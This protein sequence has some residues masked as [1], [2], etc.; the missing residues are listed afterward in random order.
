M[1]TPFHGRAGRV[2]ALLATTAALAV[3]ALWQAG[4]FVG[5]RIAPGTVGVPVETIEVAA[6]TTAILQEVARIHEIVGTVISRDQVDVSPRITARIV[7]IERRSGDTVAAGDV[8]ATLDDLD[9][10]ASFRAAEQAY[11]AAQSSF[12]NARSGRTGAQAALE[13]AEKEVR[14]MRELDDSKT[15]SKSQLDQSEGAYRAARAAFA[16]AEAGV[17]TAAAEVRRAA[18]NVNAARAFLDYTVLRS[19]LDGVV[20]DR[21]ADPGDMA[22]V[23][24]PI[25]RVFDP[26]RLM[27]EAS[28]REEFVSHVKLGMKARFFV[29]AIGHVAEGE[30]REIV[31]AV[32]PESRTFLVKLCLGREPKIVPGMF[33][34]LY[35]PVGS[36][37]VLS[38]PAE[39]LRRFGQL[40]IVYVRDGERIA[41]RFVKTAPEPPERLRVLSGLSEGERIVLPKGRGDE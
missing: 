8:L 41:R 9:L 16:Q 11:A 40:E 5:G 25:L 28:V 22:T 14:R 38:I 29:G 20:Y 21:L 15:V 3:L 23:G 39:F 35:L 34:R 37:R 1:I 33:G 12:E 17:M 31:P 13:T 24:N 18:E 2:V 6:D 4:V 32:D 27:L 10:A 36:E 26:D 30:V 7:K 19:P